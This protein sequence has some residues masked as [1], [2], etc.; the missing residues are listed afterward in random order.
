VVQSARQAAATA[1]HNRA[2]QARDNLSELTTPHNLEAGDWV[3]VRHEKPHKFE[4]KWFGPYQIIQKILLGTYRLQDLSGIILK[5]LVHGNRLLRA[6]V[7]TTEELKKLWAAPNFRNAL[8]RQN[9]QFDIV[10]AEPDATDALDCYLQEVDDGPNEPMSV[11]RNSGDLLIR[12]QTQTNA[13]AAATAPPV[14]ESNPLKVRILLKCRREQA[15]VLDQ[16]TNKRSRRE[17][18]VPEDVRENTTPSSF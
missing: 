18:P 14:E 15:L 7:Q 5:A 9:K 12:E 1:T 3:L 2:V 11:E 13:R 8:R 6:N 16:L 10:L 17:E 4:S